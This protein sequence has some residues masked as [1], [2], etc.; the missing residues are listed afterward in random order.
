MIASL[1]IGKDKSTGLPG[2]NYMDIL[3]RPL[4]EYAFMA[5]KHSEYVEEI[6][7]STDSPNI[8]EIGKEYDANI[9]DRPLEL[10]T[11]DALTEDTLT[12]AFE[13]MEKQVEEQIEFV[14][15]GFANAPHI[16][17]G[18]IDEGIEAL[19]D[20]DSLDSA[21]SVSEYNMFTPLRARQVNDEGVI[22]P[23][24]NHD[25]LGD[26]D[27]LSSIRGSAGDCY[28]VD[29][30]VQ[31]MRRRCFVNM[32]DG[33]LPFQWMGQNSYALENEYGFD[34]DAEWQVPVIEQ[35]LEQHGF[36]EES[37]PYEETED[38]V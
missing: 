17:P 8:K 23:Y 4:V 14:S 21:F 38:G 28:Y 34:I 26:E 36:S 27:Q 2:K 6:F 16:P 30:A 5:A 22:E 1:I 13:Q 18:M 15:L 31:I 20:D 9:I 37:T 24:I 29:L 35:W 25:H 12:H 32:E 3:G 10:A 7:V 19:Q 33:N 11:P